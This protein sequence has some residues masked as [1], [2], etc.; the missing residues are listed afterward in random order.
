MNVALQ[1]TV[2]ELAAAVN[3][4]F[5]QKENGQSLSYL[6]LDSRK[7]AYPEETVFIAINA[8]LNGERFVAELY[9]KGVRNFIVSP[10][11]GSTEQFAGANFIAVNDGLKALQLLAAHHRFKF[12]LPVIGITGSNG[13]TIVKEWLNQLLEPDHHIVR[14]PRSFNSQIGV[15]LSVLQITNENDLGI[16]EAGIS[17]RG[18]MKLLEK[19]INPQYGIFTHA[20]KAHNEGFSGMKEKVEEKL[21]LFLH[22]SLLIYRSDNDI[23]RSAVQHFVKRRNRGLELFHWGMRENAVLKIVSVQKG[24]NFSVIEARYQ[25]NLMSIT[26]PFTDDASI[27]NAI[28]CWCMLLYL[29]VEEAVVKERMR[30]LSRVE[31]RL[32]L[33]EGVNNCLIINDS[34]SADLDSLAIALDFLEQQTTHQKRTVILSDIL[35]SGKRKERLYKEVASVLEKRHVDRFIGI[36]PDI[37]AAKAFFNFTDASWYNSTEDFLNDVK[38][39]SFRDE[40]IL[41]KGARLFGFEKIDRLLEHQVHQTVLSI[42]LSALLHNL[43]VYRSRIHR[44]TKLMAMVKAFSYGSGSHEIAGLL[45]FHKADYLAVAYADEGVELRKGGIVLPIMVMNPEE[46]SFHAFVEHSLEPEIFSFSMLSSFDKFLQASGMDNF[47]VHIKLDTGMHRLGFG[48][49]DVAEL[50]EHLKQSRRVR[51][52]S[53][54]SHLVASE[55]HDADAFTKHQAE[56]F[57]NSCAIIEKAIGYS[58]LKHISNTEGI[59]RHPDIQMDMVRLGIGLYGVDSEPEMQNRLKTVGTLKTTVAQIRKVAAGESVGYGRN[60]FTDRESLIAV[61][62]IGYADGYPR[63]LSNGAGSMLINGHLVPVI[64]NVCM[65]MTMLDITDV[66]NINEGDEVI[67]FGEQLPITQLATWANTIPYEIMTGISQ[68]V[69]RIYFEE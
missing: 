17:T 45:E 66:S 52:A 61:V 49:D 39:S 36:G 50:G 12:S 2:D 64:G 27:E 37:T 31:M 9:N 54:F 56:S 43:N 53:V 57:N 62:R 18:E 21:K 19:I 33:K 22:A 30:S 48:E 38:P 51:V 44:S 1:Y 69:K 68:R 24:R 59:T 5:L 7:L 16:F 20:G 46:N 26:I 65:D 4:R 11:F 47:P 58:F 35:Q 60:H 55:D 8:R 13:K 41:V 32:E 3:G 34:Y 14:S 6:L 29:G 10:R 67:V 28:S 23:V 40:T 63:S 15:P 25:N 42:D